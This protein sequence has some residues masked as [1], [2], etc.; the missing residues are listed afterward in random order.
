MTYQKKGLLYGWRFSPTIKNIPLDCANWMQ[1]QALTR[2]GD[3]SQGLFH[4]KVPIDLV[5]KKL[6]V[7]RYAHSWLRP[8]CSG[9]GQRVRHALEQAGQISGVVVKPDNRTRS[10]YLGLYSLVLHLR[11]SLFFSLREPLVLRQSVHYHQITRSGLK[12][13]S[14]V[15]SYKDRRSKGSLLPWTA[16]ERRYFHLKPYILRAPAYNSKFTPPDQIEDRRWSWKK[17]N[18]WSQMLS[19]RSFETPWTIPRSRFLMS[20][21]LKVLEGSTMALPPT[22]RRS[23][24]QWRRARAVSRGRSTW[25][26]RPPSPQGSPGSP[27]SWGASSSS[28]SPFG[29][30]ALSQSCWSWWTRP[31]VTH[32]WRW[33]PSSIMPRAI[34][35]SQSAN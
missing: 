17:W 5:T 13:F 33:C 21:T 26:S 15:A 31:S 16:L 18:N 4:K 1:W 10:S 28:R 3:K 12:R 8:I 32:W 2:D 27:S 19:R 29:T 35:R 20:L 6:G 30:A 11:V 34:T 9:G 25:W 7:G 22:S 24:W 14:G 23:W